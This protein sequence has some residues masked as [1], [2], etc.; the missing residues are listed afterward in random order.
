MI[1][2][3]F[4]FCLFGKSDHAGLGD[5]VLLSDT[6]R[7]DRTALYQTVCGAAANVE[8]RTQLIDGNN[9]RVF[10]ENWLHLP[11]EKAKSFFDKHNLPARFLQ[12][13]SV[14]RFLPCLAQQMRHGKARGIP[15]GRSLC[16]FQGSMKS[17]FSCLLLYKERQCA[18]ISASE[19]Q[20]SFVRTWQ[21]R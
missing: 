14:L 17:G 3:N 13:H 9:I 10:F 4:S 1:S 6:D 12:P 5:E 20:E 11:F 15:S 21:K 7:L 8:H 19:F 16:C 2:T 18:R